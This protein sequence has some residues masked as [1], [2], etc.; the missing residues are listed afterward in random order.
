M[1]TEAPSGFITHDIN[2]IPRWQQAR[3]EC[4]PPGWV[5][6][7]SPGSCPRCRVWKEQKEPCTF[8]TAWQPLCEPSSSASN[9]SPTQRDQSI[10]PCHLPWATGWVLR[11]KDTEDSGARSDVPC[12]GF[13]WCSSLAQGIPLQ[14]APLSWA[15]LDSVCWVIQ[16]LFIYS[17]QVYSPTRSLP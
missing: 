12:L 17:V 4:P 2:T 3:F 11:R 6:A 7:L 10:C 16:I 14:A 15:T 9:M 13:C 5:P 1:E 8:Q